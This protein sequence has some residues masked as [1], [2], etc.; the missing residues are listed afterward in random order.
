M[1]QLSIR[2][3]FSTLLVLGGCANWPAGGHGGMAEHY[4]EALTPVMPDQ[5]LGPEHGLRFDLDLARQ[6][7]DILILEGAELC[8]PATV[9]QARQRQNDITRELYGNLDFDAANN[10]IV[11]RKLLARLERQLDYVRQQNVC[12]LPMPMTV[13]Q[14]KPGDIGKRIYDLLNGD[15]Q[16]SPDSPELNPKYVGQ[17]AE[18]AQLLRNQPGYHLHI[19]GHPD[20][21]EKPAYNRTLSL[22]RAKK[23]GRYLHVMGLPAERIQIDVIGSDHPLLVDDDKPTHTKQVTRRVSIELIEAPALVQTTRK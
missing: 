20:T 3:I 21:F 9:I 15:N 23:I 7:L 13:G 4:Q 14:E 6:H 17:L 2:V 19:T 18:A 12:I 11:Q 10:L 1:R 8:F 5:P 16:F 22:Q